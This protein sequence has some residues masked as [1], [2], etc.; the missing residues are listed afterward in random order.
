[1]GGRPRTIPREEALPLFKQGMGDVEVATYFTEKGK[2]ISKQG[3]RL[4]RLELEKEGILEGRTRRR[5]RR[6]KVAEVKRG[7][8]AYSFDQIQEAVL[9]TFRQAMSAEELAEENNKL[10]NI[11]AAQQITIKGLENDLKEVREYNLLRQQGKLPTPLTAGGKAPQAKITPDD[12]AYFTYH[13]D[14]ATQNSVVPANIMEDILPGPS[15]YNII[16]GQWLNPAVT[17]LLEERELEEDKA[18]FNDK[19]CVLWQ[20]R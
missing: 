18:R 10:R 1:M 17:K 19:N 14:C 16:L 4:I 20:R 15:W 7:D 8:N 2:R 9:K 13:I 5:G 12:R 6:P 3:I 11:N